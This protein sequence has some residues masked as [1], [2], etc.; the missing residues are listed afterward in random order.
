MKEATAKE[1]AEMI[2]RSLVMIA[3]DSSG[4]RT[5]FRHKQRGTLWEL[6]YPRSEGH[7]GGQPRLRELQ[8]NDPADW[9]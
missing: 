6:D 2:A 7:G 9:T 1:I 4:W 5:L 3:T 8:L